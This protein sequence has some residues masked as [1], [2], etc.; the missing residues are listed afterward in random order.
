M[1]WKAP[2]RTQCDYSSHDVPANLA[3]CLTKFIASVD[4]WILRSLRLWVLD[5]LS[6]TTSFEKVEDI[7][8]LHHSS[9]I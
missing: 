5:G 8:P 4:G 2:R 9:L 7:F 1:P 3:K 6:P